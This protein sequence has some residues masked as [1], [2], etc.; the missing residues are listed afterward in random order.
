MKKKEKIRDWYNSRYRQ[1]GTESWRPYEAYEIYMDL[2][3]IQEGQR[4]LDVACGTG[5]LLKQ[6]SEIGAKTFGVDISSEAVDISKNNSPMSEIEVSDGENLNY[7]DG[8]F[9][10]L[11][12]IGALEHFS[13]IDKGLSEFYRVTQ[14]DALLCVVLPNSQYFYWL[15]RQKKGTEQYGIKEK[16]ATLDEW[17]SLLQNSGYEIVKVLQ[18]TWIFRKLRLF[19]PLNPVKI[20]CKILSRLLYRLIPLK[21][22]YQFI[23]I[24]KKK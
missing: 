11:T 17:S 14:K 15:L 6:A 4:F 22:T 16:L 21:Y 10:R 8:F 12:C 9:D 5:Y 2:L 3:N 19:K 18:D 20:V 1:K 23:F 24:L 7:P 13:D